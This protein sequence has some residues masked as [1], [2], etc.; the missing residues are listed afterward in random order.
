MPLWQGVI[1]LNQMK[2][3]FQLGI[4]IICCVAPKA[5]TCNSNFGQSAFNNQADYLESA[6]DI[7]LSDSG[8]YVFS[9]RQNLFI[10]NSEIS[11]DCEELWWNEIGN[12]TDHFTNFRFNNVDR[13]ADGGFVGCGAYAYFDTI[14]NQW[15]EKKISLIKYDNN[16]DTLWTSKVGDG[17]LF[18]IGLQAKQCADGGFVVVGLTY[19]DNILPKVCVARFNTNGDTLWTNHYEIG[20]G[21]GEWGMTVVETEE[22]DFIIGGDVYQEVGG[23]ANNNL[24]LKIDASG[25][26]ID[27]K[28][29]GDWI[30]FN[31]PA[32]VEKTSDGNFIYCSS[33]GNENASSYEHFFCKF[34]S[35]LDT[36]WTG[37][38]PV[39]NFYGGGF[40][41][42]ENPDHSFITAGVGY[43]NLDLEQMEGTLVKINSQGNL[44][45]HRHYQN[46]DSVFFINALYDVIRTPSGGYAACGQTLDAPLGQQYW[47]LITDSMG[48]V[49]PGCDTLVSVFNLEKNF[50]G[51]EVYPNPASDRVN[52]YFES[53]DPHP[54]GKFTL[55]NMQGQKVDQFPVNN[56]AVSYILDVNHQ[57]SGMYILEYT[58]DKGHKMQKKVVRE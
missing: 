50:I 15:N 14:L 18:H 2:K 40:S 55:Y 26:Y 23:D 13:C 35:N 47:V 22:G 3:Y 30:G 49:V 41:I 45:W 7:E 8:L 19:V 10:L 58:D 11:Y 27:H 36:I 51:F 17:I 5:Q 1:F 46:A 54:N 31:G 28:I 4:W 48:C 29:I 16:L 9:S 53:L 37:Q 20:V 25:N 43:S 34:D 24:L 33:T 21:Y 6:G 12:E 52:I 38:Y 44:L 56:R 42:K 32:M 57:P 39:S